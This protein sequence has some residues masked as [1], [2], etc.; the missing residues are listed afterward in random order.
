MVSFLRLALN[1]QFGQRLPNKIRKESREAS[2]QLKQS[3]ASSPFF[4]L[5]Y[6]RP[7]AFCSEKTVSRGCHGA[8]LPRV[9]CAHASAAH[10]SR[11]RPH[12][13]SLSIWKYLAAADQGLPAGLHRNCL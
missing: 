9:L 6:T 1:D 11:R 4:I 2:R 5:C 7:H 13:R 8:H 12:K 3:Y 10:R